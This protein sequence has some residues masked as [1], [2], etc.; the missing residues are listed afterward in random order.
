LAR[1]G[2][3]GKALAVGA[4]Q[5]AGGAEGAIRSERRLWFDSGRMQSQ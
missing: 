1:G 2:A 3:A 5:R 4:A